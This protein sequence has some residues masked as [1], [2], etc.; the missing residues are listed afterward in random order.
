MQEHLDL[1][2][3][4]YREWLLG[5]S[6]PEISNANEWRSTLEGA[7]W[8]D[9]DYTDAQL[10]AWKVS[11]HLV[12]LREMSH[13][14]A[15]PKSSLH[16]DGQLNDAVLRA[17]DHWL[18]ARYKNVNWWH[19]DIGVPQLMRDIIILLNGRL[20]DARLHDARRKGA[21]EVLHQHG[22]ARPGDGANTI[23]QAELGL[24][25]GA[26]TQDA[27]MVGEQSTL[28]SNEIHVT[29]AEGIQSD[30]SFHAHGARLQQFHYGGDFIH[31]A[32]RLSWLLSN[33]PWAIPQPKLNIV[34]DC[35]LEGGQWMC[36]GIH[37][38]PSTLDRSISRPNALRSG[39]MRETLRL[40]RAALP[41]RAAELDAVLARQN[42]S[43]PALVGFRSFPRS[44]FTA[45]HRPA[46]SF[47][48]K[49]ISNRTLLAEAINNE[50]LKGHLL[51][52]GDHY[53]L[54]DG[55]EYSDLAPA[56]DWDLLPGITWAHG[57]G[58]VMRQ[59][60]VG[61][62]GDGASGATAMDYRFANGENQTLGA[63]KF[64]AC[65]GDAVVCLIADLRASTPGAP[66][67]TA[68]DQCLLRGE[69]TIGNEN[70]EV[71]VLPAGHH[72]TLKLRWIHHAGFAYLPL[73]E[74]P[75]TL[76]L[77]DATGTWHS[78]NISRSS[79]Q[80]TIPVFLPVLEHGAQP[81]GQSSGYALISCP[82][83]Q[84]AAQCAALPAW[85]V[86]RNDANCQAMRFSDG[87]VMA[88]FYRPGRID[89]PGVLWQVDQPCLVMLGQGQLRACDP[90]QQGIAINLII[91]EKSVSLETP[92]G[93]RTSAPLEI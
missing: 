85:Q 8:P 14:L 30:W 48:L 41:Q 46:F 86:L 63:R 16:N 11:E 59:P 19:N 12:R 68:L 2:I 25:Y 55:Q 58:E 45:Y 75:V 40:L 4:R 70:G 60:F 28:I 1:I 50:N 56:W 82:L 72:D 27:A 9:I 6:L 5:Q 36:R 81:D 87:T 13:A 61:A 73:G 20:Q 43:A 47:F 90:T 23:W 7:Q 84:Q 69:V 39:D 93:G 91:G 37:T 66:I 77:G 92:D 22:K 44:D 52:C 62:I 34:A 18:A 57:A 15:D 33:T 24:I 88:V 29:D 17:L 49:T 42:G 89:A 76:Q 21:L 26:L 53:L 38:V 67:R 3:A 35:I 71:K 32:A 78:I 83:P 31:D 79:E 80:V 65:H 54:R 10:A 51:N 64:W 74:L